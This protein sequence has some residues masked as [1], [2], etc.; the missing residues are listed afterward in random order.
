MEEKTLVEDSYYTKVAPNQVASEMQ[1]DINYH[2][3]N[4]WEV[5]HAYNHPAVGRTVVLR[6]KAGQ[7]NTYTARLI[8]C[9]NNMLH[10]PERYDYNKAH[11]V[12][13]DLTRLAIN[14]DDAEV[15]RSIKGLMDIPVLPSEL[16][17]ILY[18][19]FKDILV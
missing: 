13:C 19:H 15:V 6:K 5:L 1:K 3:A 8:H 11:A 2:V 12:L 7:V 17:S 4:G 16:K 9:A 10:G 18:A 14:A